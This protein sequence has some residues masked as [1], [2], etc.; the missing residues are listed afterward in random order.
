M[1]HNKCPICKRKNV[2]TFWCTRKQ[3]CMCALCMR[4]YNPPYMTLMEFTTGN[5]RRLWNLEVG[6][7]EEF[8]NP[9]EIKWCGWMVRSRQ[10]TVYKPEVRAIVY[11]MEYF[12][13]AVCGRC[14]NYQ[15]FEPGDK[16]LAAACEKAAGTPKLKAE[17]QYPPERSR[18][19][20]WTNLT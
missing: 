19:V 12:G 16:C 10:E 3:R 8:S 13:D 5:Y 20:K 17:I 11:H 18:Y 15:Y 4:M 1:T 9:E 14:V 2:E 6:I 7:Y